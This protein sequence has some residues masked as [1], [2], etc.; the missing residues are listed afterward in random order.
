MHYRIEYTEKG[1]H[2]S[3]RLHALETD[4]DARRIYNNFKKSMAER[5]DVVVGE[6]IFVE[7]EEKIRRVRV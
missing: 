5:E 4:E 3:H 6:L 1:V 2:T 7:E